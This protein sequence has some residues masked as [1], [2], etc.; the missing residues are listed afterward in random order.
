MRRRH[1]DGQ[2]VVQTAVGVAEHLVFVDDQQLG[3]VTVDQSVFLGLK[4]GNDD[5]CVKVFGEVTGGDADVPA[6]GTPLREFVIGQ[7]TGG[8]GVDRLAWVTALVGPQFEDER[9]AR[10]GRCMHHHILSITKMLHRLLLPKIRHDNLIQGG[11]LLQRL[12]KR[13]HRDT[14]P[15]SARTSKSTLGQ[16]LGTPAAQ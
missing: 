2:F 11:K 12:P 10:P 14:L 9:F 16:A 6:T 3:A 8:H 1:R 7:G 5:R 15:K 13:R 4:R